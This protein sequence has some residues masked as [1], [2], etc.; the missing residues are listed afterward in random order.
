MHRTFGFFVLGFVFTSLGSVTVRAQTVPAATNLSNPTAGAQPSVSTTAPEQTSGVRAAQ[1]HLRRALEHFRQHRYVDAIH[2]FELANRATPSADLWY[3][4]ARCHELLSHYD[5]AVEYYRRYLRDK[6][7]PPDR[8]DV[9]RRIAELQRL[10]EQQRAA[11]RRQVT[12]ARVRFEV[13]TPGAALY[14]DDRLVGRS[15]ML[16]A[17][18]V[19]P[20]THPIRVVA[21][22]MQEWRGAVRVRR[23]E[24]ITAFVTPRAATQYRTRGGGHLLSYIVGA[25]S[26]GALGTGVAFGIGAWT[27]PPCE[28]P[29]D[30][31]MPAPP[32]PRRDNATVADIS[33]GIGAGLLLTAVVTYF[34]EAGS[35][36][37]ERVGEAPTASV[38]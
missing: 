18:T 16:E 29:L 15:P 3:N 23:G 10:A 34:L 28:A 13:S 11:A 14:L 19:D 26:L 38:R 1:E 25:A 6:V 12:T 7:D 32:C 27:S 30:P 5:E 37:T 4:I 17:V 31:T 21:P 24:T 9:E 2:E 35:S 36:R 33:F 22:G 8:A 20:G